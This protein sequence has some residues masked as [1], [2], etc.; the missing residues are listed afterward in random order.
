MGWRRESSSRPLRPFAIVSYLTIR[1]GLSK[2]EKIREV[3]TKRRR[4]TPGITML[5]H[6]VGLVKVRVL[7]GVNLAI[8]DLCSSDPYV[9]IRMGKQVGVSHLLLLGRPPR[10]ANTTAAPIRP[11]NLL[12]FRIMFS[13]LGSCGRKEQS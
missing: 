5:G 8:R 13:F 3:Q 11:A 2:A 9:V 7:R 1:L 12:I 4:G 6:L 10:Q